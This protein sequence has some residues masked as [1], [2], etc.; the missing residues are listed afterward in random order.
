MTLSTLGLKSETQVLVGAHATQ[1]ANFCDIHAVDQICL[2]GST[3]FWF[4]RFMTRQLIKKLRAQT[5]ATVVA[6]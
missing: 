3:R 5:N 2:V 1:L 6:I 4:D